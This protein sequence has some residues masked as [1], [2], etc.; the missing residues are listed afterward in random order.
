[1]VNVHEIGHTLVARLLG[2]ASAHYVLYESGGH[3]SCLGCNLYDSSKLSDNANAIVNFG[4][5][6][7]TQALC[8]G[9]IV[10]LAR[11]SRPRLEPWMA[12]TGIAIAWSGDL[13]L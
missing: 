3:S 13:L 12:L 5:V 7:S 4:G 9:A 10:L 1:M 8:W 6:L 2:D 11:R